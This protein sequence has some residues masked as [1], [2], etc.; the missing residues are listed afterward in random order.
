MVVDVGGLTVVG[1]CS[2]VHIHKAWH[3]NDALGRSSTLL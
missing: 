1:S 2:Q 3:L